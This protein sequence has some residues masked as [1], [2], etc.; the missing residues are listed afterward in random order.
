MSKSTVLRLLGID[1]GTS[2]S[3]VRVKRYQDGKPLGDGFSSIGVTF[4]NGQGDTRASTVVRKNADGSFTCGREAEEPA[5]GSTVYREF[6][7]DLESPDPEKR[8]NARMQTREFFRYLYRWYDHQRSDMGEAGDRE[9]TMVSFPVKW[10]PE[11][12]AFMVEAAQ[13][14]GF[15][16]VSAMDEPSA[17]LYATLC[18]K[19]NEI[20]AQGLLRAGE[21][22]YM[23]LVDMGAGTT[24]LAVCRYVVEGDGGLIRAEQIRMEIVAAWPEDA[25]APT[26]G[27]REVDRLLE[28][29]L[30]SY[31][32]ACGLDGTMARQLVTGNMSVKLWKEN[33]VSPYLNG[34]KWVDT[35]GF[36]N[37][38]LMLL[39][40]KKPFPAF[41]R[42]GF[43]AMLGKK[44][45]DFK[46]LVTGCLEK[47]CRVE[48]DIGRNG[49]DLVVL[50]GGHSSWY[51][52]EEL[53]NGAMPGLDLPQ[54]RRVQQER[55]R[56]LRLSNPQETVALGMV[57]SQLPVK[58]A[59]RKRQD[60]VEP[61]Q[62]Q[63]PAGDPA[64]GEKVQEAAQNA[65][66]R[67]TDGETAVET[68]PLQDTDGRYLSTYELLTRTA[69]AYLRENAGPAFQ[70]V[71]NGT[72]QAFP[73]PGK[74]DSVGCC[75][76]DGGKLGFA[77]NDSGLFL[78]EEIGFIADK[79]RSISWMELMDSRISVGRGGFDVQIK[80]GTW[81]APMRSCY[82]GEIEY[83][84]E[85]LQKLQAHLRG[86][87][88]GKNWQE[89]YPWD[90]R[91]C[92][93][94]RRVFA[95]MGNPQLVSTA[96]AFNTLMSVCGVARGE[97]ILCAVDTSLFN[98]GK[99]G[100]VLTPRRIY[101]KPDFE[102]NEIIP[103]S[104]WMQGDPGYGR[105][106]L[107]DRKNIREKLEQALRADAI[108]L[109]GR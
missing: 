73:F 7:M 53:L 21:P 95:A 5:P 25:S 88:P 105:F 107:R 96:A 61:V 98:S 14:A 54:L 78:R 71:M 32:G 72:K 79:E 13:S 85:L 30:A 97:E 23:L 70:Q 48:P 41:D 109:R 29:F 15:P 1:F 103:W 104:R 2:T 64:A 59:E 57:Y 63:R 24:D 80:Q 74:T 58:V 35:C 91:L 26:F 99:N 37:G 11:T 87:C 89:V 28:D 84:V 101:F 60:T 42:G 68:Y 50:T 44:L 18:R 106:V 108:A 77:F 83:M 6:K 19:M 81:T 36:L 34:G 100:Y 8:E 69:A 66:I 75:H 12:R 9:Q 92:D 17:A 33:T 102:P 90:D 62:E 3:V 49:V 31:I 22:G 94:V 56:V 76:A 16:E 55:A 86:S 27:G 52:T 4:G 51:F 10:A 40:N 82:P 39:P 65:D 46:A 67:P 47:A 45:E 43:E 20:S 38:Y 93:T